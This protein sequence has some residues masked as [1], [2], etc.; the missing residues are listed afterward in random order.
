MTVQRKEIKEINK[1]LLS[2]EVKVITSGPNLSITQCARIN[3]K[4]HTQILPD[5][6]YLNLDSGE[7]RNITHHDSRQD[8]ISNLYRTFRAIRNIIDTNITDTRH[9]L[10]ITLTYS[11]P[12]RD[13]NKL[14]LDFK[15][16]R[17]KLNRYCKSKDW[18][19]PEYITIAEPQGNGS[20]HLHVFFIWDN[21]D[22][23]YIPHTDLTALWNH[24]FTHI[25]RVTNIT[26]LGAYFTFSLANLSYENTMANIGKKAQY[27]AQ[28]KQIENKA[29]FEDGE[30]KSK[31]IIKGERL[32]LYP[33][34]F[35]ILRMSRGIK[36]PKIER[37][38]RYDADSL[39][40]S[41]NK[42]YE[43]AIQ[44]L[45]DNGNIINTVVKEFYR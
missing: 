34:G 9:T 43:N 11:Y 24:G 16:L 44:I 5:G 21:M 36:R 7:V 29:V 22:A 8:H 17:K 14:Y 12:M 13:T 6:Q 38:S 28:G 1:T 33:A 2:N 23:P 41:F 45:D 26:N 3:T 15:Q 32:H 37:M 31:F 35:R 25:R 20:W 19:N 42:V 27:L 18:S 40:A 10:A 4:P 30:I 39:V